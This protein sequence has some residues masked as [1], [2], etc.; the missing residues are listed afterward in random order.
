MCRR[1]YVAGTLSRSSASPRR[2]GEVDELGGSRHATLRGVDDLLDALLLGLALLLEVAADGLDLA[3]HARAV[4]LD[5]TLRTAAALTELALHPRARPLDAALGAVA[6]SRAAALET[7]QV[8]LDALLCGL[9]RAVG[10]C[11]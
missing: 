8:A 5:G 7:A 3:L 6:S 10:L 1:G 9:G 2:A 4:A 11:Q